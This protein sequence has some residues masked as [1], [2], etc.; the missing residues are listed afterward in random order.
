LR[1]G[2]HH[3]LYRQHALQALPFSCSSPF[4]LLFA[5][6]CFALLCLDSILLELNI[7]VSILSN[8]SSRESKSQDAAFSNTPNKRAGLV[9]YY[10]HHNLI[11]LHHSSSSHHEIS[12]RLTTTSPSQCPETSDLKAVDPYHRILQRQSPRH[13]GNEEYRGW[14][15]Y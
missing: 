2:T 4:R 10:H 15:G 3:R 14:R 6:L 9:S 5:L 7:F 12:R 11:T 8:P 1:S 13:R